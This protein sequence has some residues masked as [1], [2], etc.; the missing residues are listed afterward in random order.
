MFPNIWDGTT[1]NVTPILY[2]RMF[3]KMLCRVEPCN[4]NCTVLSV[5]LYYGINFIWS[6]TCIL[7]MPTDFVVAGTEGG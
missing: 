3:K 5:W 6:M 7:S 1:H 4:E 2:L